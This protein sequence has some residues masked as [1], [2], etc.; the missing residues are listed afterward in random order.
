MR[1]KIPILG[2]LILASAL[3]QHDVCFSDDFKMPAFKLKDVDGNMVSSSDFEGKV[4]LLNFWATWCGPCKREIPDLIKLRDSYKDRGFEV[5][6]IAVSSGTPEKVR[7]FAKQWKMNYPI[8]MGNYKVA[9]DYGGISSV[10][11]TFVIDS[12]GNIKGVFIGPRSYKTFEKVI[13]PILPEA[14]KPQKK[15]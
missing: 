11:T 15:N 3:F 1:N 9:R 4:L 13:S 12:K 10:P 2:I 7:Q 6:S 5:V 14:K 8:L